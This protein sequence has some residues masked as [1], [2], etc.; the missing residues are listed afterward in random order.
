MS[1]PKLRLLSCIVGAM[2]A[3]TSAQVNASIESQMEEVFGA[4]SNITQ[5]GAYQTQRRGVLSGGSVQ[6][7]NRVMSTNLVSLQL[8]SFRAGCGGIDLFAGSFSFIN[9]EQFVQMLRTIASNAAG[10]AFQLA[11]EGAS[12][13]VA[14]TISYLQSIAQKMN[15]L[16]MNSCQIAQGIVN[17]GAK[18]LGYNHQHEASISGMLKGFYSDITE[19]KSSGEGQTP[20]N[21]PEATADQEGNILWKSLTAANAKAAIPAAGTDADEY[22]ELMSLTGTII[23]TKPEANDEGEQA[24]KVTHLPSL[25]DLKHIVEGGEVIVYECNDGDCMNPTQ[26][27]KTIVG[28]NERIK[29]ALI[30]V[31][32]STGIVYKLKMSSGNEPTALEAGVLN[33]MGAGYAMVRNLSLASLDS[34]DFIEQLAYATAMSYAV[35]YADRMIKIATTSLANSE[36][37]EAT[38]LIRTLEERRR[39]LSSQYDA[40]SKEHPTL[41]ALTSTYNEIMRNMPPVDLAFTRPAPTKD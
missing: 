27:T 25:L 40:L 37:Q 29:N 19:A 6:V 14:N 26:K 17:D 4:M 11:L 2:L 28:L 1:T 18:L 15:S 16:N 39:A 12:P 9:A 24:P 3:T 30:G 32:G 35:D 7:R 20:Y 36:A 8:P 41:V 23:M 31:D 10:Y 34:E 21:Q 38:K 13:T 5:P 33:N 22:G